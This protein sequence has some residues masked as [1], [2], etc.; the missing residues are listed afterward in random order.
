VREASLTRNGDQARIGGDDGVADGM[1]ER[2]VRGGDLSEENP[3][4]Q[5]RE[6]R[7]T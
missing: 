2:D 4:S 1:L 7:V 5:K 6:A 3:V